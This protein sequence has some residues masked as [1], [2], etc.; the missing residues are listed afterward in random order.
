MTRTSAD[1]P[2]VKELIR[3]NL[4]QTLSTDDRIRQIKEIAFDDEARFFELSPASD[5]EEHSRARQ[6]SRR[7][8]AL[9]VIETV[10]EGPLTLAVQGVGG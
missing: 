10:T 2:I 4:V 1:S 3:L 9:V 7:W 6:A 8:E 5:V